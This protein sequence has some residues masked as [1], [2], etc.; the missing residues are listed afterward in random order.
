MKKYK[1]AIIGVT[2]NVGREILNILHNRK[3]PIDKVFGVA[4]EKSEGTKIS[5]G[6]DKN[7]LV[8]SLEK[9]DFKNVDIV[10]SSPGSKVSAKFTP[11][12]TKEG[13]NASEG[14]IR[15]IGYSANHGKHGGSLATLLFYPA[16]A[17]RAPQSRR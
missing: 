2:G 14:S 12:A 7:I 1:V 6:D 11:K 10:L 13:A 4:S 17:A 8:E 5:Y 9:F 3:F 16:A 15:A